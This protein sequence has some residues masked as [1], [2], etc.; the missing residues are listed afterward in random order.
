MTLNEK[1]DAIKYLKS[2][3]VKF[4]RYEF[5]AWLRDKEK[6]ILSQLNLPTSLTYLDEGPITYSQYLHL[7]EI[8]SDFEDKYNSGR[9]KQYTL[10]VTSEIKE[11]LYK[12]CINIIREEKLDRLFGDE[13]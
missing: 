8:I 6:E 4:Q 10:Q 7:L 9:E 12:K 13:S 5:A 11:Y 3:V 1:V 2:V